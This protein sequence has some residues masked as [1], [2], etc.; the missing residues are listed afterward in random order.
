MPPVRIN[1]L[2]IT[3]KSRAKEVDKKE[4]ENKSKNDKNDKNDRN[5]ATSSSKDKK[6]EVSWIFFFSK[7]LTLKYIKYSLTESEI[8]N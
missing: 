6:L 1:Y 4:D 7:K 3:K 2:S 5:D 8:K